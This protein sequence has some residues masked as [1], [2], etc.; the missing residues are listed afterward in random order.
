MKGLW[1]AA[2][3]MLIV[4]C[5]GT[6]APPPAAAVQRY[7]PFEVGKVYALDYP[8]TETGLV[9]KVRVLEIREGG[10]MRVDAFTGAT[11]AIWVNANCVYVAE[12]VITP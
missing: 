5:A 8:R 7:G 1:L 2:I 12:E 6:S 4:S 3:L 10:W 9:S 11:H